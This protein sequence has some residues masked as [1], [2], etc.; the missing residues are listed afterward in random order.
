MK[1]L[2]S[3]PDSRD[4]S[5]VRPC[6]TRSII[7]TPGSPLHATPVLLPPAPLLPRAGAGPGP[8]K[9]ITTITTDW[10]EINCDPNRRQEAAKGGEVKEEKTELDKIMET[11]PCGICGEFGHMNLAC[12]QRR[13]LG[14][15]G[16]AAAAAAAGPASSDR[17]P[18]AYV[19]PH[20][21]QQEQGPQPAIK[22][23]NL[24]E[25]LDDDSLAVL[26]HE[27]TSKR[28][29]SRPAR[30]MMMRDK[31]TGKSRGFAIVNYHSTADKDAALAVLDGYKYSN[32][33][34][35]ADDFVPKDDGRGPRGKGRE[36]S[37]LEE[38]AA[39]GRGDFTLARPWRR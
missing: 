16:S 26:M 39:G 19:P 3:P 2:A 17:R 6:L 8:E 35:Q 36:E 9:T 25:D 31:I 5:G 29:L 18:G 24:P 23:S 28:Q 27:V 10:I 22:I 15:S 13:Q 12:P 34:L 20:L 14:P 33:V 32:V 38:R 7:S 4:R 37:S 30:V 1:L 21:Q 11:K